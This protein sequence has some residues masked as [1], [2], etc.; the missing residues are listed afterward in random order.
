MC[1][2]FQQSS[3]PFSAPFSRP[4]S[5]RRGFPAPRGATPGRA[6]QPLP[7]SA[8]GCGALRRLPDLPTPPPRLPPRR[9]PPGSRASS[10]GCA[11]AERS[12]LRGSWQR[13]AASSIFLALDIHF[14]VFFQ[15]VNP[16][17]S[18]L[19]LPTPPPRPAR[20]LS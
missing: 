1:A 2:L 9:A 7:G 14:H 15:S 3:R 17:Y 20:S 16:K 18:V 11:P 13:P 5:L 6:R 4:K 10:G 19:A 12:R 8:G